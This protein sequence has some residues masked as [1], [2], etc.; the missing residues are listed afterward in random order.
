MNFINHIEVLKD[1]LT[2]YNIL[3]NNVIHKEI[4]LKGIIIN[5]NYNGLNLLV[6]KIQY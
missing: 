6:K 3:K 4:H 5:R 1:Y 2:N